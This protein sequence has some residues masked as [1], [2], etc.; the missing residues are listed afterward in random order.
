MPK[1]T[2]TCYLQK[3]AKL[4]AEKPLVRLQNWNRCQAHVR[5]MYKYT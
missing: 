4:E 2:Y 3:P 5:S 1:Y